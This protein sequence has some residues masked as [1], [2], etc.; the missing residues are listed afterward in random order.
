MVF[1]EQS[2]Q[3]CSHP[4][5][6]R[7]KRVEGPRDATVGITLKN[8]YCS[9]QAQGLAPCPILLPEHLLGPSGTRHGTAQ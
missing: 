9:H 8:S 2:R 7:D 3:G 4:S 1:N 5:P 6:D